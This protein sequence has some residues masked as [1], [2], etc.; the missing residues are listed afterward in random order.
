MW[1]LLR[2]LPLW[3][4]FTTLLAATDARFDRAAGNLDSHA[5]EDSSVPRVG[6]QALRRSRSI[7]RLLYRK[8]PPKGGN[9]YDCDS[10]VRLFNDIYSD[11]ETGSVGV[12]PSLPCFQLEKGDDNIGVGAPDLLPHTGDTVPTTDAPSP[13]PTSH[14]PTLSG[15][16]PTPTVGSVVYTPYVEATFYLA[17]LPRRPS[18]PLEVTT[19]LTDFLNDTLPDPWTVFLDN[20]TG[21]TRYRRHLSTVNEE[22]L[23]LVL[24]AVDNTIQRRDNAAWWWK[25]SLS[26]FCY[27]GIT[28]EQVWQPEVLSYVTSVVVEAINSTSFLGLLQQSPLQPD[29][30]EFAYGA[31]PPP[32]VTTPSSS[33]T[34]ED[35]STLEGENMFQPV[36]PRHWDARRW[37]GLGTFTFTVVGFALLSHV[38][39]V[40]QKKRQRKQV[41][42]HV[43]TVEGIDELLRTGWHVSG[44]KM[45]I[46]DRS[47]LGYR[48]DDSLFQGGYEQKE[49]IIGLAISMTRPESGT[50]RTPDT[51]RGS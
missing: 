29:L 35:D 34:D 48:D 12:I 45:E 50:T 18:Q 17:L 20:Y 21:P 28:G 1:H 47:G 49:T 40:R 14:S 11:N 37:F 44:N 15:E 36:D 30:I 6:R 24:W 7:Q 26:Y 5:A 27:N 39:A 32:N 16:T 51:E 23:D 2:H 10:V 46:Y 19:V 4:L 31:L 41:W 22:P 9:A 43:G 42:G 25:Y 3:C 33:F 13:A 38:A 8:D